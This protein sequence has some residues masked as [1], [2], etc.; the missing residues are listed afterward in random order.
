MGH[1]QWAYFA[2]AVA[3]IAGDPY[4]TLWQFDG[5]R[6]SMLNELGRLLP[7]SIRRQ[8]AAYIRRVV[9][10]DPS[11]SIYLPSHLGKHA[12]FFKSQDRGPGLPVPPEE[13][14]AGYG[15][16]AETYISQGQLDVV[17]MA[18]VL[19]EN[20]FSLDT[21]RVLE[22]GCAAGRMLRHVAQY[23]PKAEMWGVDISAEHIQW[24]VN[25]LTPEMNF[26]TTTTTP[27]LPFEDRYFDL[28]FSGS[29]L[30][31][32]EDLQQSWLLELARVLRSAGRLYITI[33]DEYTV[34]QLDAGPNHELAKMLNQD[35]VYVS[36]K[37]NFDLIV[38][39][40]GPWS[41]VFYNS[42]YFQTI[43]PPSL[44]WISHT[45]EAYWQ[46]SAVV[47]EKI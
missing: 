2:L 13:L 41:Q 8:M 42:R 40:R 38:I 23:A 32:I 35:P 47:L 34:A 12:Y 37:N 27:H 19:E 21:N 3:I 31:H 36:N 16:D 43:L 44:R 9:A 22:F 11:Y 14:W 46:Q 17:S 1:A 15:P 28:I 20:G 6:A 7:R 26:A 24:C 5:I 4:C 30:T 10:M 33:H 29:V 39:G 18:R 25:N 45:P